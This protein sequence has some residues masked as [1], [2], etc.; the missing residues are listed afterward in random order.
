MV[1][2]PR[3]LFHVLAWKQINWNWI[4]VVFKTTDEK[5][6]VCM[7]FYVQGRPL[8]FRINC[9][10]WYEK[11]FL[12][13]WKFHFKPTEKPT[14]QMGS[15]APLLPPLFQRL[16]DW[17][18]PAQGTKLETHRKWLVFYSLDSQKELIV[19]S[20]SPRPSPEDEMW[21]GVWEEEEE[22]TYPQL[23]IWLAY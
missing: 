19:E 14:V 5:K 12:L 17:A 1:P 22:P 23:L 21:P 9:F 18:V 4:A 8:T 2:F 16:S 3:F 13:V 7:G 11:L 20:T 6:W 15:S 10:Y